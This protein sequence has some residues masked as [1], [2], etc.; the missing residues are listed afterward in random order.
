MGIS[1]SC[2]VCGTEA[3]ETPQ[4]YLLNCLVAKRAWE[5]FRTVWLKWGAPREVTPTWPFIL[6]GKAIYEGEDNLPSLQGYHVEGFCYN[7]Q[8]LDIF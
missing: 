6:F 5:A 4:H 8:P 7:R 3:L 2:K 1:P